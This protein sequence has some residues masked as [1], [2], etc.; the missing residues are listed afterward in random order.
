MLT[1]LWKELIQLACSHTLTFVFDFHTLVSFHTLSYTGITFLMAEFH[2]FTPSACLDASVVRLLAG[3]YTNTSFLVAE[4]GYI[5]FYTASVYAPLIR[6][7]VTVGITWRTTWIALIPKASIVR[8]TI[9]M[10]V[11]SIH[12]SAPILDTGV[13]F[14]TI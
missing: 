1:N 5:I 12:L 14:W 13:S 9:R 6:C 2:A 8:P 3:T 7:T 11:A 10:S 4:I